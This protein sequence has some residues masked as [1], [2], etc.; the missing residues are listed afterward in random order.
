MILQLTPHRQV[1]ARLDARRPEL[2]R[3]P[4]TGQQQQVG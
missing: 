4:D 2:V 3:R 1:D